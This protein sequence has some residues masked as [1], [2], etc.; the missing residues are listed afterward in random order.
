MAGSPTDP[1]RPA[2]LGVKG[3]CA[4][5]SLRWLRPLDPGDLGRFRSTQAPDGAAARPGCCGHH[6]RQERCGARRAAEGRN[7]VTSEPEPRGAPQPSRNARSAATEPGSTALTEPVGPRDAT[8]TERPLRALRRSERPAHASR[9]RGRS[10]TPRRLSRDARRATSGTSAA[11]RNERDE[12]RSAQRAGRNLAALIARAGPR[13]AQRT[14]WSARRATNELVRAALIAR[15]GPRGAQRTSRTPKR[16]TGAGEACAPPPGGPPPP[17]K[18]PSPPP[19][20]TRS[21]PVP[22]PSTLSLSSRR[23]DPAGSTLRTP[24]RPGAVT[25][26]R[27][28]GRPD[29]RRHLCTPLPGGV[30]SSRNRAS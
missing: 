2:R 1:E 13:G 12:R 29:E 6:G 27:V 17:L 3:R 25:R 23:A 5:P 7:A 21:P 26:A 4:R 15:A 19:F 22:V 10:E 28:H 18:T 11:A 16:A 9:A 30:V 20:A 8:A 24:K 14:S